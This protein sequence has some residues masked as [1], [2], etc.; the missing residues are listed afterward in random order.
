MR[1]WLVVVI[2][3]AG[4]DRVLGLERPCDE[5]RFGSTCST[6]GGVGQA[7][8]ASATTC[9][10]GLFCGDGTC[11]ECV[12]D[13]APG[14]RHMCSLRYDGTVWCSGQNENAQRGSMVSEDRVTVPEQLLAA[15]G[16]PFGD[17][18]S[19][20]AGRN[21]TCAVRRDGTVWCWGRNSQG[22]L[23]NGLTALDRS[24]TP[25]QVI[26][27]N[28]TPITSIV[29]VRAGYCHT[30]ALDSGKGV[31]CWGCGSIGELG[32]GTQQ[33]R[34]L[35][36][37]V[38][39]ATLTQ[40]ITD[41]VE[42]TVGHNHSCVR[43]TSGVVHCWGDNQHGQIGDGRRGTVAVVLA[44]YKVLENVSMVAAGSFFTCATKVDGTAWCWG[45]ADGDRIGD[46]NDDLPEDK[47]IPTSVTQSF[48]GPPFLGATEVSVGTAAC[49]RGEGARVWCWGKD[50]YGTTGGGGS[51]VPA[52]VV[53]SDGTQLA[54]VDRL[55]GHYAHTCAHQ[56]S[57]R[58]VCWGR[59]TSGQLANGTFAHTGTPATLQL[60]CP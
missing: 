38:L 7:C 60:T 1:S 3:L 17:V 33:G 19:I 22:Q 28:G 37:P 20:A 12:L 27:A 45:R 44:P 6:C 30:C 50:Q 54:D 15:D 23:G 53:T 29:A 26:R 43:T 56:T 32:D 4:C 35:A 10:D 5:A 14:R 2:A 39:D 31:L 57:G 55:V 8:C 40:P 18:V 9:G 25:T 46:G 49:L 48:L 42:I 24:P 41:V 59:N 16:E 21:H 58:F 52:P 11:N 47:D 34:A 36:A 51:T 13:V